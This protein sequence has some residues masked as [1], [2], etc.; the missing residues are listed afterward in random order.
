MTGRKC[1]TTNSDAEYSGDGGDGVS[2][3][4]SVIIMRMRSIYRVA[5]GAR[6]DDNN[7][8]DKQFIGSFRSVAIRCA[9]R[10]FVVVV[11]SF[12][13]DVVILYVIFFSFFRPF[14]ASSIQAFGHTNVIRLFRLF[15]VRTRNIILYGK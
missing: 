11:C 10:H 8:V 9:H 7:N 1:V 5:V 15:S 6:I 12:V 13:L 14:A 3:Q 4:Y 2:I